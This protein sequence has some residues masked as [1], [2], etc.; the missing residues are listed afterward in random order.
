[1]ASTTIFAPVTRAVQPAF[2]Y[3]GS[4]KK[5]KI[6]FKLSSF[7][8]GAAYTHLLY[9]IIDPSTSSLD[10]VNSMFDSGNSTV[11]EVRRSVSKDIWD[12]NTHKDPDT[13]DYWIEIDLGSGFSTFTTDKYYQV[14]LY[15]ANLTSTEAAKPMTLGWLQSNQSNISE[16]SQ[17][18][19]IRPITS[20][21]ITFSTPTSTYSFS[22]LAGAISGTSETFDSYTCEIGW[23]TYNSTTMK[24]PNNWSPRKRVKGSGTSFSIPIDNDVIVEGS[25]YHITFS[26]VTYNGYSASVTYDVE[27]KA[28]DTDASSGPKITR[29]TANSE[30]G[31]IFIEG[32]NGTLQRSSNGSSWK[33]VKQDFTANWKDYVV[34]SDVSYQYRLVSSDNTTGGIS[35]WVSLSLEDIFLSEET[36]MIAIRLNPSIS[37]FKYVTQESITNTLGGKYPIVNRNGDTHYRQFTLNGTIDN[38]VAHTI[39]YSSSVANPTFQDSVVG[40][41]FPTLAV[42]TS[43]RLPSS[44]NTTENRLRA[45][46]EI[47]NATMT[48]LLNG[49]PKLFRSFE[50]GSMIVYLSN[51][52][53]TPNKALGRH[54]YDF[55]ATVTEICDCTVE[56]MNKYKLDL[57]G[58]I[59]PA[60][61]G[62]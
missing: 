40:S 55:S 15:L 1:M 27:Y 42:Q 9:S 61:S 59:L 36:A 5:V 21:S 29:L 39:I 41:F 7:N 50:E 62:S 6:Y 52:S 51:I 32:G 45:E 58:Y 56:N 17:P 47:K 34:D 14:Q 44:L 13:G 46:R 38:T 22:T 18:T 26:Y 37:N 10:A 3:S 28:P 30:E 49:K 60:L 35:D 12:T 53:F 23:G 25:T 2:I 11:T 43:L 8:R 31:N 54:I 20:P 33:T 24:Y 57:G 19:L 4:T 16:G 48:Q